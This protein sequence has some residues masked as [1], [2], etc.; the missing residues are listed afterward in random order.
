MSADEAQQKQVSRHLFRQVTD[1]CPMTYRMLSREQAITVQQARLY[2]QA[3]LDDPAVQERNISATYIV[4]GTLKRR[5]STH[6]DNGTPNGR[7]P[8][9]GNGNGDDADDDDGDNKMDVDHTEDNGA[10]SSQ[11][12]AGSSTMSSQ[13]TN[14]VSTKTILIVPQAQLEGEYTLQKFVGTP[15]RHIYALSQGSIK[16]VSILATSALYC[17]PESAI[18]KWK[19]TPEGGYGGIVNPDGAKKRNTTTSSGKKMSA[20]T[21]DSKGKGKETTTIASTTSKTTSKSST[22]GTSSTKTITRPIGQLGGLFADQ[23]TSTSKSTV[24]T[25]R[26]VTESTTK[27]STTTTKSKDGS[28]RAGKSNGI[29]GDEELDSDQDFGDD[30]MDAWDE[31]A[32]REAEQQAATKTKG[33]R[34]RS[35]SYDGSSK[36]IKKQAVEDS[37]DV[38]PKGKSPIESVAT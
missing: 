4:T 17:Q 11:P 18:K 24:P 35:A 12:Q 26:K 28:K 33:Q 37:K 16:D 9:D 21:V 30:D 6:L 2:M 27:A 22:A 5:H 8:H 29:F 3:W 31:E 13:R 1:A 14:H 15:T 10:A 19:P 32:M 34:S 38:K 7:H 23:N 25:K 36:V 20:L